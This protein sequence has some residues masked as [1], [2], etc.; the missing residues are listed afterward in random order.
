[1]FGGLVKV[2]V[3]VGVRYAVYFSHGEDVALTFINSWRF[4]WSTFEN[5]CVRRTNHVTM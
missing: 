4:T 2:S 1:M 5:L 3:R